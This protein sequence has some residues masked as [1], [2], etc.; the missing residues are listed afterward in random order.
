MGGN[1]GK[2][3]V[4]LSNAKY[5]AIVVSLLLLLLLLQLDPR[6]YLMAPS[7][8]PDRRRALPSSL[9][10]TASL[11]DFSDLPD[12]HKGEIGFESS[13][14]LASM[15]DERRRRTPSSEY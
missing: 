5:F 4:S 10:L 1:G 7:K 14:R 2:Q 13:S 12:F 3:F 9:N 8:L 6:T 15:A 11:A